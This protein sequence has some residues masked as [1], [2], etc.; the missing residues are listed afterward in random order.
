MNKTIIRR[1]TSS[2][3]A[4]LS[5]LSP[6]LQRIYSVRNVLTPEDLS[7]ELKN[8]LPFSLLLDID[9]ATTR[10][11][12]AIHGDEHIVIVGDFDVDGA[13]ST[14]VAVKALRTFGAK[15]VSY[16]LPNRFAYGYGLSP[17]M[18]QLTKTQYDPKLIVT[19]DNGISSHEGVTIANE[20]GIDVIITDHH[21]PGRDLPK[22]Y[23]IVNPNRPDDPFPSKC[24]AGVGV[25]FYVMLA[26]RSLLNEQNWF[27]SSRTCPNMAQF[28]DYVAL[29]T[30]ADLVPL[31]KNNRILVHQGLQ[32]IR[33][34]KAH[35][36]IL[37][38]LDTAGCK[39]HRLV[40]KDLGFSIAPRLNAAGRLD[41]MTLGVACLLAENFE[42]AKNIAVR[43]DNL[44]KD[45]RTMEFRMQVEAMTALNQ[46]N[47]SKELPMGLCL[48]KE[49]WHQGLVGLLA[50]RL[51]EMLNR[52]VIVF[53]KS[54][55]NN[56]KGSARSVPGLHVRDLLETIAKK[57]PDLISKFGGHA[58]AAGLSLPLHCFNHFQDI[59]AQEVKTQ[60]PEDTLYPKLLTDG[61]LDL[62]ELTLPNA[63]L[64]QMLEPWGQ[65][66][67]EPLFD[68]HFR[69]INQRLV[70]GRHLKLVLQ[71]PN[72]PHYI[73]GIAFNV[74]LKQWPN[75]HCIQAHIAYRL[76]VNEYRGQRKLQLLVESISPSALPLH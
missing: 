61:E 76:D 29:G 27:N 20:L 50:S 33:N 25:I 19:V 53:A 39:A 64:L 41:D 62:K 23:A 69:V 26:L 54:D 38:L 71:L 18:V 35:P 75:H 3:S 8:L 45:R 73:D 60:F 42:S 6:L 15:K 4:A 2:I 46:L 48:Y 24:L 72:T 31:D 22:A 37:A 74:D 58:M 47:L 65:D 16:L 13:T 30:V 68:G 17:Q 43:L 14:A 1:A 34:G 44:N 66:F 10:L 51:K 28:L 12:Q 21:L 56:L 49:E 52:P 36:G 40:P 9:R 11:S 67:P 7:K 55:E 70:G 32:R 5:H 57:H 63:E 59:F